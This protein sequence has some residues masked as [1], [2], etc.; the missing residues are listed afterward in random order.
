M[1][2]NESIKFLSVVAG[3]LSLS[4][5]LNPVMAQEYDDM[6]FNKSDRK[7]VKSNK[8]NTLAVE[9]KEN[10]TAK[11]NKVTES[12]DV[13]SSKNVNPEY[14][15][16]YKSTEISELEEKSYDSDDYFIEDY[17]KEQ[18]GSDSLRNQI[19]YAAL[20]KRDQMSYS[21]YNRT[22]S[23]P[24][25][26][27][28]PYMN[29]SYGNPYCYDPFMSGYGPSMG[30]GMGMGF[31]SGF[32][33]S[34][35]YNIGMSWGSGYNPYG[36]FYGYNPYSARYRGM[37]GF[38]DP[39]G[40]AYGY[41]PYRGGYS[42]YYGGYGSSI[43]ILPGGS[44][45]ANTRKI[46]HKPRSVNRSSSYSRTSANPRRESARVS[47]SSQKI[48]V[49]NRS[50][51]TTSSANGR[52]SRD[53]S[54]SQNEYY[55]SARRSSSS[56]SQR[57]SSSSNNRNT[58]RRSSSNSTSRYSSSMNAN[59]PSRVS[60]SSYSN[61]RSSSYSGNNS[62]SG[63]YASPSRSNSSS[64]GSYSSGSS[65]SRSSSYSSSGSSGSGRSYSSGSS[66]RSSS[67]RGRSGRQ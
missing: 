64:Y 11:Y 22:N 62:R 67:S 13:Y 66:S 59:K 17:H 2:A 61:S 24:S 49:P 29:M 19:N 27:F 16:R 12:T 46:E 38:Y 42:P 50:L 36:G 6:Y 25:W 3:F 20:N 54:R 53:Y 58:Y 18:Y 21:N 31:G 33:P 43:Y 8:Y 57:I 56:S 35:S 48:R 63:S 4:I 1:K 51:S 52:V 45:I 39:W 32:Y 60:N 30:F 23:S 5:I 47:N 40:P 34:M 44:D 9:S 65:N 15:A 28:S 7:T 55:N 26:G 41:N 37:N 10:S 14:I